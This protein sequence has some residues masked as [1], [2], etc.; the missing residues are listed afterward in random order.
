MQK[1]IR[2]WSRLPDKVV[3]TGELNKFKGEEGIHLQSCNIAWPVHSE[4]K[5][6]NN[7]QEEIWGLG[8]PP[9]SLIQPNL[10]MAHLLALSA[11][12]T[13]LII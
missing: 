10:Y 4:R 3:E 5:L 7:G 9:V 6:N 13:D 2:M 12:F 11:E 1:V 8:G